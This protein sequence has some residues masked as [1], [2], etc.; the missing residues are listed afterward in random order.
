[1]NI[2]TCEELPCKTKNKLT[3]INEWET[4]NE[5]TQCSTSCGPGTQTRNRACKKVKLNIF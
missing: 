1:M 2:R 5:W 3:G 4:W